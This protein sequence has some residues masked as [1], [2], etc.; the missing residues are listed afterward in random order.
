MKR[1]HLDSPII[2]VRSFWT[3]ELT[4]TTRYSPWSLIP[5]NKQQ[6]I[7]R[8]AQ[9]LFFDAMQKNMINKIKKFK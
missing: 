6:R 5:D 3:L 7:N 1:I 4:P 9:G 8:N 2:N